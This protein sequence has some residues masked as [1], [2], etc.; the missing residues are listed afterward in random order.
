MI[1]IKIY[2][3]NI[4]V[5]VTLRTFT[6]WI[7]ASVING[8]LCGTYIFILRQDEQFIPLIF[9]SGIASLFFAIPGFFIFWIIMLSAVAKTIY[10]RALFRAALLTGLILSIIT[11]IISSRLFVDI[12]PAARL[13]FPF[14][15]IVSGITGIM[16]HF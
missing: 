10:G 14:F 7:M 9:F 4:Y 6:I 13:V 8:L 11:G 2:L 12:S 5:S 1:A 3:M 15:I 16:M